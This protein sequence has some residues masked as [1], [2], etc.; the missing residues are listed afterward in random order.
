MESSSGIR[1]FLSKLNCDSKK[2]MLFLFVVSETK[3][4]HYNFSIK[5]WSHC[6]LTW[7]ETDQLLPW[8][9]LSHLI[10]SSL[11]FFVEYF[12][13]GTG[14]TSKCF[15]RG[16]KTLQPVCSEEGACRVVLFQAADV[17][18]SLCS[19][20]VQTAVCRGRVG[21]PG[22]CCCCS[23][24]HCCCWETSWASWA[25]LKDDRCTAR[26]WI[27]VNE[28]RLMSKRRKD[29]SWQS[30]H[31]GGRVQL[32]PHTGL[33]TLQHQPEPLPTSSCPHVSVTHTLSHTYRS[34]SPAT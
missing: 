9:V 13:F 24:C 14:K 22:R 19:L 23:C 4:E 12:N 2:R 15:H 21:R 29:G 1:F 34:E 30:D 6:D 27:P 20:S 33:H 11:L 8:C 3:Q 32:Q 17:C 5:Y 16:F 25:A 7:L 18:V 10:S 28:R 31:H 26:C